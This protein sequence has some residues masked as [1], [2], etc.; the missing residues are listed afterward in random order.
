MSLASLP[1]YREY[2]FDISPIGSISR[3]P[4]LTSLPAYRK[5]V[6]DILPIGSISGLPN[7]TSLPA[8]REYVF[9][10]LPIGSI[11]GSLSLMC[12]HVRSLRLRSMYVLDIFL[13]GISYS[14]SLVYLCVHR[15]YVYTAGFIP[16][17][18][19]LTGICLSMYSPRVAE[20]C[21]RYGLSVH[22]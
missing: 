16:C 9:D 10:I 17:R 5:C 2:V 15:L 21:L 3:L 4:S 8:Y 6:F 11:P 12:L 14:P 20:N 13:T 18:P 1:A 19:S 22:S 7:L